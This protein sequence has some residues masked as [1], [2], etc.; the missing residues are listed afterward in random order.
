VGNNL[1]ISTTTPPTG[2]I[3]IQASQTGSVRHAIAFWCS[4]KIVVKG[5][6]QGLVMTG[7]EVSDPINGYVKS[8]AVFSATPRN[9]AKSFVDNFLLLISSRRCSIN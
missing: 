9:S 2:S 5:E 6:V 4:N 7:Q 1:T 3:D 8:K